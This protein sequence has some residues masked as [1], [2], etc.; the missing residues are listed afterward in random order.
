MKPIITHFTDTDLYKLTMCCAI[1]NCFP[2]AV[3]K[4]QFVDRNNTI[5]PQ[6]FAEE[7]KQQVKYLEDLRFTAEE[8]A[9]M[10]SRCYYLPTWFYT[11]LRGFRYDASWVEISQDA[12]GHLHVDFEGYWHQTV[13]LEVQILAIISELHHTMTGN[14]AKVDMNDYYDLT[15]RKAVRMLEGGLVVSD[16]GLRRRLS[17]ESEDVSVRAFI[18]ASKHV[19]TGKFVGTSNVYLAMKHNVTPVGT[20]AHEW[21]SGIAGMFGPQEANN[22]AMDMWQKTYIGS[23]GIFLYDTFGFKAFADNFSEHFARVFAGLRIDSGNEL[24]QVEKIQNKYHELGVDHRTK[25]IIFSNALDTDRALDIH[26]RVKD[27]CIDS[28]GIG[29]H[30]TCDT[31]GWGFTPMNIVIKLVAIKITEKRE[32]NDT[33]KMSEDL[34]KYTGKP[35]TV[36][37]FKTLLHI[38]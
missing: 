33:C 13:L 20:M 32:F 15:Y 6:G 26:R 29:T 9:F 31:Y 3:V 24:E 19:S 5:Y 2:R 34:G 30:I 25:Q 12:E 35:E 22:I 28:Y 36:A 37:L 16:F 23:L 4:Y 11:F 10:K 17:F 14:L 1:L 8:E 21:I 18:E 7:L 38:K 27:R